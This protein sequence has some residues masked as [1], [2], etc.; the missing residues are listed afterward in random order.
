[1]YG[2]CIVVSTDTGVGVGAQEGTRVGDPESGAADPT[3]QE[4]NKSNIET[5][6]LLFQR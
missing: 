5:L 6:F 3:G 4:W 2:K 1:M